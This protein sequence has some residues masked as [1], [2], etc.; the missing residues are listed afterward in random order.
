MLRE[1]EEIRKRLSE[2]TPGEWGHMHGYGA[3]TNRDGNLSA[4]K[5]DS[6]GK[7]N[8]DIILCVYAKN[9]LAFLLSL[10]DR[11]AAAEKVVEAARRV[12]EADD[13]RASDLGA[14]IVTMEIA[15]EDYDAAKSRAE[16]GE[17]K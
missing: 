16:A 7:P 10:A 15:I 12:S 17:E 11:L 8:A 5:L 4:L 2:A 9:D 13:R 6:D 3:Y 14:Y 1:V